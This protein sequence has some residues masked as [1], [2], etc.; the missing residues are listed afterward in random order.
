MARRR[1]LPYLWAFPNTLLGL[2]LAA[3]AV[4]GK[5]RVRVVGGVVEAHGPVL[6]RI[7]RRF[8]LVRGASAMTLGHVVIGRDQHC[9]EWSRDHERVHVRQ[10]ERWGPFFLPLYCLSSL[11]ALL[12]GRDPYRG[13]RFER[14]AFREADDP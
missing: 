1:L 5:G 11:L 4:V 14:E 9:L 6:D 2:V 10:Y 7:L 12:A 8:L 13:N 3:T